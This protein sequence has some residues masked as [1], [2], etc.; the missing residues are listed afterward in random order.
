MTVQ[1]FKKGPDYIDPSWLR[2]AS[3]RDCYNLDSFMMPT[4]A[5]IGSFALHAQSADLALVEGAMG[6]YDGYSD[7]G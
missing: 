2:A 5:V 1:C 6:L 4:E 3:G 7:D